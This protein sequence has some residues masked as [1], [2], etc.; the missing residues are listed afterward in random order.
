MKAQDDLEAAWK[1]LGQALFVLDAAPAP[2]P[3]RAQTVRVALTVHLNGLAD[4][5]EGR[6]AR[7]ELHPTE[8]AHNCGPCRGEAIGRAHDDPLPETPPDARLIDARR[9]GE[10]ESEQR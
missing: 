1:R 10:L 3:L 2:G 8:L 4:N 5:A 6:K 7:C 9:V